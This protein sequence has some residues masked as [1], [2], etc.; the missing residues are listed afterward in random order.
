MT[1]RSEDYSPS[2][3]RKQEKCLHVKSASLVGD[4]SREKLIMV[5][6]NLTDVP[7]FVNDESHA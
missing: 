5:G 7:E 6:C 4:V 1:M 2:C 3:P